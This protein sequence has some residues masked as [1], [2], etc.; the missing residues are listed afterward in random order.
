M[1]YDLSSDCEAAIA[2]VREANMLGVM[3]GDEK[4]Q[5]FLHDHIP[6]CSLCSKASKDYA[7]GA[8]LPDYFPLLTKED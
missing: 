2:I 3:Q 6:R 5:R 4:I 7:P 1:R 8:D